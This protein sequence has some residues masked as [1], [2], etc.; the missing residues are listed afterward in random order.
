LALN[1]L[2]FLLQKNGR[3]DEARCSFDRAIVLSEQ[4]LH[5]QPTSAAALSGLA[6]SYNNLGYLLSQSGDG[7]LP[8]R[9]EQ[10][11][12]VH[13]KA[14]AIYEQLV[15]DDPESTSYSNYLAI[16]Y[17]NMANRM[18]DANRPKPAPS[19]FK[20]VSRFGWTG[21]A[22]IRSPLT[23]G[24]MSQPC[25]AVWAVCTGGF[26]S[27]SRIGSNGHCRRVRRRE[28]FAKDY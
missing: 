19:C 12:E 1:G 4:L 14:R 13:E 24:W 9:A 25:I 27:N 26:L 22:A 2:G 16:T 5:K 7:T 11:I 20:N 6:M 17:S 3:F 23:R 10:A 18:L 8:E 21:C 28:N 15:R